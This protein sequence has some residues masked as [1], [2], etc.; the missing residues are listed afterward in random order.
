VDL[1]LMIDETAAR[2]P[3]REYDSMEKMLIGI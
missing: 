3:L 2:I 1:S